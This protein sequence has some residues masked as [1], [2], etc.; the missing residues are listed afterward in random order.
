LSLVTL[1]PLLPLPLPLSVSFQ[2]I[3]QSVSV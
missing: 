1:V 3:N 2:S